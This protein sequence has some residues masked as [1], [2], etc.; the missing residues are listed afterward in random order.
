MK[1]QG[2]KTNQKTPHLLSFNKYEKEKIPR[3]FSCLPE[4]A[5][6]GRRGGYVFAAVHSVSSDFAAI[7]SVSTG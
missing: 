5:L 4:I 6:L 3:Q 1:T 7:P 2:L